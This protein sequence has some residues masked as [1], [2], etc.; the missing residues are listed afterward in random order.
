MYK[1]VIDF[2]KTLYGGRDFIPLSVPLFCGN[3]K[4]YLE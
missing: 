1:Q 4:K 3:E 2:I